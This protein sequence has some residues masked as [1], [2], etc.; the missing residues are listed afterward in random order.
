MAQAGR[1]LP[2][3]P[4]GHRMA[5][6]LPAAFACSLVLAAGPAAADSPA[7]QGSWA[8]AEHGWALASEGIDCRPR[9]D[10]C[11]T[12]N[13]GATWRGIFRGQ[14]QDFERTS[15]R[16]GVVSVGD[17]VFWTRD[18]ARH[19]YRTHKI[20]GHFAGRGGLLFATSDSDLYRVTP[21]PPRGRVRCRVVSRRAAGDSR[22]T[23]AGRAGVCTG[24]GADSAMR[25]RLV[26]T[27]QGSSIGDLASVPGGVFGISD[28]EDDPGRLNAFVW[29]LGKLTQ[30]ALPFPSEGWWCCAEV[31]AAWPRLFVTALVYSPPGSA[32]DPL[33]VV[34]QSADGG[35]AWSAYVK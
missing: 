27:V 33:E 15:V 26:A 10:L 2:P 17:D 35:A 8:D 20:F 18:S 31:H 34:W 9:A 29:R 19:W 1:P 32:A 4:F 21:W 11:A 28:V 24:T 22:A 30:A 16:A 25:A 23:R 6:F 3:V 7:Q 5:R 13:G 14:V 12:E